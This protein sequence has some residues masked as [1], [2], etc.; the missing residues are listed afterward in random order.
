MTP[1]SWGLA[2]P[3]PS[4]S[5]SCAYLQGAE[6]SRR[7]TVGFCFIQSPSA[8]AHPWHSQKAAW[9]GQVSPP[10]VGAC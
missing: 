5:G 2:L 3:F 10:A 6:L 1:D 8:N 7:A 4:I 9:V